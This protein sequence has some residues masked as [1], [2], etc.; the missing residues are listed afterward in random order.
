MKHNDF[1]VGEKGFVDGNSI[2]ECCLDE[3]ATEWLINDATNYR[4]R[5]LKYKVP[6][7]SAVFGKGTILTREKQARDRLNSFH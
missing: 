3:S 1:T 2:R 6:Y 4:E 7:E 5:T